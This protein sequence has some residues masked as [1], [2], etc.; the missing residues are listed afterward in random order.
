MQENT[1]YF[2]ILCEAKQQIR[3]RYTHEEPY[4]IHSTQLPISGALG[5]S[6]ASTACSDK[7]C[8]IKSVMADKASLLRD[9]LALVKGSF[10]SVNSLQF[11]R[12]SLEGSCTQTASMEHLLV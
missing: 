6:A 2:F 7:L 4:P 8:E 11:F 3:I 1:D 12:V 9:G 10:T 5:S